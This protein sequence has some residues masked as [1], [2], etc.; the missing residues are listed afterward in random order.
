MKKIFLALG[1]LLLTSLACSFTV[2]LPEMKVGDTQ[3]LR[4]DEALPS[5]TDP[6][7]LSI[8][9]GAG[10]LDLNGG[11]DK[12]VT[13]TIDY[14]VADWQPRVT[15]SGNN[16]DIVQT[17]T[18]NLGK[19]NKTII[20]KWD[21]AL[22]NYPLDIDIQAGAYEGKLELGGVPINQLKI[23]DG[24]SKATINFE[25]ANPIRMST[26]TYKTGASSINLLGLGNA[27]FE[28]MIFEGGTGNYELDFSGTL[29][30]D[31]NVRITAGLSNMRITVPQGVPCKVTV[32]GGL[33]NISPR[34]TWTISNNVYE[35]TGSGP[36]L[37]I[38]IE[39]GL[40][41]LDLISE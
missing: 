24:A 32:T 16:L 33:S 2:N 39:M 5:G 8:E 11:S 9:M 22:G 23:Q 19:P 21:L 27:N 40:G 25:Q 31:A 4:V 38:N 30:A 20:N 13:G 14:N 17:R 6:V 12:L 1:I 41:N 15:R 34:G 35:Q 7:R 26:L 29:Q 3:T 28:D 36:M 37:T 10:T 18:S